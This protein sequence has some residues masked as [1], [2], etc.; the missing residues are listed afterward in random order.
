MIIWG[1]FTVRQRNKYK[2]R[3]K[4]RRP[5]ESH[6]FTYLRIINQIIFF[7]RYSVLFP[8]LF[9]GNI[10]G[11]HGFDFPGFQSGSVVMRGWVRPCTSRCQGETWDHRV[12]CTQSGNGRFL[13]YIPSWWSCSSYHHAQ[14]CSV[15]S[16]HSCWGGRYSPHI[17]SIQCTVCKELQIWFLCICAACTETEFC[18]GFWA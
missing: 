5:L 13:A 11:S 3:L 14:S 6:T 1:S 16:V 4:F 9:F 17:S 12:Q 15:V 18:W 10:H 2:I 8:S 7:I